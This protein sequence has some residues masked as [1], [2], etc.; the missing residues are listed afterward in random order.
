MRKA[1]VILSAVAIFAV[2]AGAFAFKARTLNTFWT[3]DP[4]DG[5]CSVEYK[6]TLKTTAPS[7]PGAIAVSYSTALTT[8]TCRTFV[9]TTI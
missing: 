6:T 9:T 1:K 5:I 2:V 3:S 4:V 8:T 7:F